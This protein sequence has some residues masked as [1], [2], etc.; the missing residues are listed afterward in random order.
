MA[1][2]G[3]TTIRQRQIAAGVH[4]DIVAKALRELHQME[5]DEMMEA[6]RV[7]VFQPVVKDVLVAV[8]QKFNRF[9][10]LVFEYVGRTK[11][12]KEVVVKIAKAKNRPRLSRVWMESLERAVIQEGTLLYAQTLKDEIGLGAH[13]TASKEQP[14]TKRRLSIAELLK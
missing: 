2:L 4:S 8:L 13:I 14:Q 6:I 1:E 9:P 12:G 11:D 7:L 10:L 5:P 3:E